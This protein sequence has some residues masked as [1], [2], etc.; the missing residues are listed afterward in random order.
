MVIRSTPGDGWDTSAG[1][2]MPSSS[3][4]PSRSARSL[5]CADDAAV[6]LGEV[7]LVDAVARMREALREVAV[8]RQQ[9]EPLGVR[10]EPADREHP[11]LGRDDLDDCRSSVRIARG[12][13][14]SA[15]LVQQVVHEPGLHA[16]RDA[17]DLHSVDVGV[18]RDGRAPRRPR[19]RSPDPR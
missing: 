19:S 13:D 15:R 3:S 6:D 8:V 18:D 1:A 7:L 11:R 10:V 2:V 12:R 16:D 17:V 4:M 5:P 14:D 9:Q